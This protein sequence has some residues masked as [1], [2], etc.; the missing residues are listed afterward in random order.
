MSESEC[1]GLQPRCN[2]EEQ[3]LKLT[4]FFSFH[5]DISTPV[6]LYINY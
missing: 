1:L 4:I 3:A 6:R 5:T 2:N